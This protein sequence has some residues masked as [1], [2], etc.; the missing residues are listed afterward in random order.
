MKKAV[1]AVLLLLLGLGVIL[2]PVGPG[3]PLWYPREGTL[4]VAGSWTW[5]LRWR[6]QTLSSPLS[7]QVSLATPE[8]AT[9]A[10]RATV[11]LAPE[12]LLRLVPAATATEGLEARMRELLPRPALPCLANPA[13]RHGLE[14]EAGAL[15]AAGLGRVGAVEVYLEPDPAALAAWRRQELRQRVGSPPRRVLVV[16][17][18][19]GDWELL[20]PLAAQGVMP[21]LRR[22]M[23]VGT[24]GYLNSLTP[25]LS[26]LIATGEPPERHGI[27]DFLEVDEATG[28]RVPVTSRKRRVPALWNMASAAGLRVGVSGWWATWPAE[29]VNGVLVSDRLFFLLSDAPGDAP[30]GTVVFPAQREEEFRQ[31]VARAEEETDAPTVHAFLPVGL[32][33]V[34]EAFRAARG[35]ADPLDGFRRIMVG[36]R[37]YLGA[38][39]A[40]AADRPHLLMAYCIGTDEVGHLLAPYLPP[41]GPERDPALVQV[42]RAGVERY[43]AVVDRWLGRLL[44]QCPLTECAVL[45]VSDHGFKWGEDRPRE[46][47]GV[48]AATAALWHRPQGIFVLAGHG[49]RTLGRVAAPASVYDVAPTVAALLQ[50]P[51]GAGW[52]GQP[53][54]GVP[55]AKGEGVDWLALVPPESYRPRVQAVRPSPE[56]VAQL[57]AL[58]YLE[59]GEGQGSGGSSTEG[60]LNNLGLLHLEAGRWTEAEQAFRQ[61][62]AANPAYAS[63]HYNLRRLYF[64]LRRYEEADRELL[65]ALRLGLRDGPGALQRAIADYEALGMR[66]RALHLAREG[67]RLYPQ[68]PLWTLAQ[69]RF[70]VELNRC[71]EA[72]ELATEAVVRFSH[73]AGVLAFAGLAAACAGDANLARSWM[74]RSL[75]LNPNQPE[76]RHAL[77]QLSP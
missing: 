39:L 33:R 8:G 74:E 59:G 17:W 10:A 58:G 67:S 65:E 35:M 69:L 38:A 28:Q 7:A 12:T 73:E 46:F 60:E 20:A 22:L 51:Q 44:E 43:F 21:N 37:V 6:S 56:Y 9:V 62:I 16:G 42:A 76:L 4:R 1:L 75:A 2:R 19:G 31:L 24:Y 36:T 77:S 72:K 32:A 25:L 47:S 5:V 53:L 57:K 14:Q 49:V 40:M 15:L 64:Q 29:A 54:P 30:P 52:R 55:L 66:E 3:T 68:K 23:E 13:C 63:P 26:P 18:D 70:L 50:L 11:Q 48:A 71:G 41:A 45:V 61:A 27:L 34:E